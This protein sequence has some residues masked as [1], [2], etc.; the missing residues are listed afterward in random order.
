MHCVVLHSS[1][2]TRLSMKHPQVLYG[3]SGWLE[4]GSN[5]MIDCY[6]L[7]RKMFYI[8]R[9]L[10]VSVIDSSYITLTT[11]E[12]KTISTINVNSVPFCSSVFYRTHRLQNSA[13]R[14]LI[15]LCLSFLTGKM[16]LYLQE[17][18]ASCKVYKCMT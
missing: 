11:C 14:D 4:L 16:W 3:V 13:P 15:P 10:H 7:S 12:I 9:V 1:K 2:G 6:E 5:N 17:G 8:E 18:L